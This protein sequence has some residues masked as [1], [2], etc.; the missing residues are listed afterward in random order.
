MFRLHEPR[1]PDLGYRDQPHLPAHPHRADEPGLLPR[2]VP[3]W[4]LY[5]LYSLYSIRVVLSHD[6]SVEDCRW[7]TDRTSTLTGH[8]RSIWSLSVVPTGSSYVLNRIA[9]LSGCG[10]CRCCRWISHPDP[11]RSHEYRPLSADGGLLTLPRMTLPFE[12]SYRLFQANQAK[13]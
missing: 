3:G 8:A 12:W 10:C 6:P 9:S 4:R 7:S 11:L 1:R 13:D 2:D 5:S